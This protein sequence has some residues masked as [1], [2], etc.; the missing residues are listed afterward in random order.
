MSQMSMVNV[1]VK[2]WVRHFEEQAVKGSS[3]RS[4]SNR[5]YII[6][7]PV[8]EKNIEEKKTSSG[9]SEV[10]V[11]SPVEQTVQQAEEEVKREEGG[12]K[13]K[14]EVESNLYSSSKGGKNNHFKRKFG[15]LRKISGKRKKK[16]IINDIFAE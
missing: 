1:D 8:P 11:V 15:D 6:V 10:S 14:A 4:T 12:S 2:P 3:Q 5:H 16:R 9:S 13:V 7:Q